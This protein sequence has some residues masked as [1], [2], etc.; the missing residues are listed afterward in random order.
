MA[1]HARAF[2]FV[3]RITH[4]EPGRRITGSYRVP[5]VAAE[6]P[7]SL[8]SEAVGQLAALAAM[9]VVDFQA[10]PVAGLAG[11]VE[12][13]GTVRPGQTLTLEATVESVDGEAASYH[14]E[15]S[16]DGV[17]VVRLHHCVGPMVPMTDFEDPAAVRTR[18]E[19][20]VRGE[21]NGHGGFTGLPELAFETEPGETGNSLRA[22]LIVPPAA[23]FFADHFPRRPV[24]PGS[25]LMHL[26]LKLAAALAA[27]LPVPSPAAR[28]SLHAVVDV[29]L[30]AFI[31]P[32]ET[33]TLEATV[34]RQTEKALTISVQSRNSARVI[35][36]AR[37][38]LKPEAET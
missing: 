21:V 5:P 8:V 15:A 24:F 19:Q 35:G 34:K 11:R 9:T 23:P 10:R 36:S 17:P 7:Q 16:A 1:A 20:A 22:R 30:R 4:C 27:T 6:F 26:N 25:L 33:L 18:F 2:T 12:L 31:P 38:E 29:K 13:L 3:D 37:V 14:G 32:G 28:W